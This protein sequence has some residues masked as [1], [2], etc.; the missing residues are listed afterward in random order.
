MIMPRSKSNFNHI[1]KAARCPAPG[2]DRT[3]NTKPIRPD[4]ALSTAIEWLLGT[5]WP[6]SRRYTADPS[7]RAAFRRRGNLALCA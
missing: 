1:R 5:A 2:N 3:E 4:N 7:L 6:M